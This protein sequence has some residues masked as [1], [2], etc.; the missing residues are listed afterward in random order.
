MTQIINYQA[1]IRELEGI[2]NIPLRS[3]E[4]K[5]VYTGSGYDDIDHAV[6]T[7]VDSHLKRKDRKT[8]KW[9][10][11][12]YADILEVV[13]GKSC[14]SHLENKE[15]EELA[16]KIHLEVGK[17]IKQLRIMD[18][19]AFLISYELDE[20]FQGVQLPEESDPELL[21]KLEEN[22]KLKKDESLVLEQFRQKFDGL[23]EQEKAA[24]EACNEE[25][26][27][28][29]ESNEEDDE[30]ALAS[31]VLDSDDEEF[32][33]GGSV[34]TGEV[35]GVANDEE[36]PFQIMDE[37]EEVP[38]QVSNTPF[39][40]LTQQSELS[41][42]YYTATDGETSSQIV[43]G[44]GVKRDIRGLDGAGDERDDNDSPLKRL[45]AES[46]PSLHEV[47]DLSS[48]DE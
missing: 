43:S 16:K 41:G 32:D 28:T 40:L 34:T 11:P 46:K 14:I 25:S 1:R 20:D 44:N 2:P 5:F 24:E 39:S 23:T 37:D 7:F 31:P 30:E 8:P 19:Q 13:T 21:A 26:S 9:C 38:L 6:S 42:D 15:L 45:R 36:P 35:M 47:V 10:T 48:D 33:K 17:K 3:I 29:E 22:C 4:K 27:E 18:S 12:N